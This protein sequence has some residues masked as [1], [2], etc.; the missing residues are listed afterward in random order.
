[1]LAI[2]DP[3]REL[4]ALPGYRVAPDMHRWSWLYDRHAQAGWLATQDAIRVTG[5]NGKGSTC[6]MLDALLTGLGLS[7]GRVTSPHLFRFN[8]RIAVNGESISDDD[9]AGAL[10]L[11]AERSRVYQLEF[12]EPFN[13]YE[14]MVAAA[15]EHFARL[16]PNVIISEAG[17]GGRFD[18]GWVFPSQLCAVT[19]VDLEHASQLGPTRLD[20]LCH[21]ADICPPA[22]TLVVGTL[23]EPLLR[24]LGAYARMRGYTLAPVQKL[25]RWHIRH[26]YPE[27]TCVDL[28]VDGL[29][30]PELRLGLVG[31]HQVSNACVALL[32]ARYWLAR[33][34]PDIDDTA[35]VSAAR[36]QLGAVRVPGRCALLQAEPPVYLD[37]A[38][39]P[40]A[41][42]AL[43]TTLAALPERRP[44][45]LVVGMSEGRMPELLLGPLLDVIDEVVV[46][47]PATGDRPH[48][49]ERLQHA[50]ATLRPELRARCAQDV[51]TA[52]HHALKRAHTLGMR[53][54]V[55]G[56]HAICSEFA[57]VLEGRRPETLQRFCW[58]R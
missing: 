8:E 33:N 20:I 43:A 24:Q 50:A 52:V 13:A 55:T 19:S 35:L 32:L 34:R 38:H 23:A 12:G 51:E 27:E 1:M 41:A 42:R 26:Q 44:T 18:P 46:C 21:K 4:L 37:V 56:G 17:K 29:S 57:Y 30:L 5:S 28:T 11:A 10:R 31:E 15:L 47:R 36:E 48:T 39:T 9:L 22:G 2:I 25:A 49:P 58:V 40:D 45:L 53:V 7:T 54:V 6:A 14:L 16:R 3:I